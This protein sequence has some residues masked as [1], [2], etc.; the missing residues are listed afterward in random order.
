MGG[1]HIAIEGNIGAGKTTLAQRLSTHINALLILEKFE[2]NPFLP[3]FYKNMDEYAFPM[4]LFFLSERVQQ[5]KELNSPTLF[6][7]YIIADFSIYKSFIFAR[8]TLKEWKFELFRRIFNLMEP[9]VPHPHLIIHIVRDVP[10]LMKNIKLRGRPYEKSIT[11][12]YLYAIEESYAY[13]F[14]GMC[15]VPV[16][17]IVAGDADLT[18]PSSLETIYQGIQKALNEKEKVVLEI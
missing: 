16:L 2:D 9:G 8:T 7:N 17:R 4:E 12:E 14:R 5:L 15:P 6:S 13:F 1:A 10:T 11:Q 3:Y 18:T